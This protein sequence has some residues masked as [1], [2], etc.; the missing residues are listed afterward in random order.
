[1]SE[2]ITIR[3]K[4]DWISPHSAESGDFLP[5][6]LSAIVLKAI[7]ELNSSISSGRVQ[8][9]SLGNRRTQESLEPIVRCEP[10]EVE[11]IYAKQ[12]K[13]TR[14]LYTT[15]RYVG[16]ATIK[17][18]DMFVRIII[19]PRM[20]A[21]VWRYLLG[22]ALN[23]YIPVDFNGSVG[24]TSSNRM[25]WLLLMMW[26]G[27]LERAIRVAS[28]PKAY[29]ETKGDVD[30]FKGRLDVAEQIKRNLTNRSRFYCSYRKLTFDNTFNRTIRRVY[31]A[32][33]SAHVS[34]GVLKSISEH[35]DK[36]LSFGVRDCDVSDQD[37]DRVKYTRM[38]E[39][40]RPVMALSKVILRGYG[41]GK[42][43][44]EE[45]PSYFVD[46]AEIWENY[47]LL[48]MRRYLDDYTVVSP[49][50]QGGEFLFE[51]ARSIR[52]D[53]LIFDKSGRLVAIADAKYKHYSR[54]GHTAKDHQAVSRDDLYQMTTYMYRL[55][56]ENNP[57]VGIFISPE[58]NV[59]EA[60]KVVKGKSNHLMAMCNLPL[61]D[62]DK[63]QSDRK[64]DDTLAELRQ[65]EKDFVMRLSGILQCAGSSD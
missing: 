29:I 46:I 15:S 52:P 4:E 14:L 54:I 31:K 65:M 50:E 19:E 49:N 34:S 11:R 9:C 18:E 24:G 57:L 39:P 23:V 37:I 55:A 60:P 6:G 63:K 59:D 5:P 28:I 51:N 26:R 44:A 27:S 10:A 25:Q 1:M 56:K 32:L 41:V 16:E 21:S 64:D 40:Y 42:S 53:F 20:G 17:I 62:L 2:F 45:C 35:D 58:T 43:G 13:I 61:F 38:T 7:T 12:S 36:L 33:L 3:L 22:S 48:V 8:L 30:C 47:L